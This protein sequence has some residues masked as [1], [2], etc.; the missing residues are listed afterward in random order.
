MLVKKHIK[1]NWKISKHP[2]NI[3]VF[4]VKHEISKSKH[5]IFR[6][7]FTVKNLEPLGVFHMLRKTGNSEIISI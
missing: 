2:A 3:Y 1:K 6:N 7:I 5:E 4:K